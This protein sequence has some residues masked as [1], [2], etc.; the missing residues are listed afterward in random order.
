MKV[1]SN[2]YVSEQVETS[3]FLPYFVEINQTRLPMDCYMYM[4]SF[5]SIY[6]F[7]Y[8]NSAKY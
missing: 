1:Y 8:C 3:I 7:I 4:Y 2:N 6:L 5:T